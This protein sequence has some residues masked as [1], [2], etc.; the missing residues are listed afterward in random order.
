MSKFGRHILRSEQEPTDLVL[1]PAAFIHDTYGEFNW[2]AILMTI[3][4]SVLGCT[5]FIATL[6]DLYIQ[7]GGHYKKEI[8]NGLSWKKHFGKKSR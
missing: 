8:R 7:Y 5:A 1:F 2:G 3:L 6:L 4:I